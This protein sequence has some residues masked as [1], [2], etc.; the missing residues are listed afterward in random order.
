MYF[1]FSVFLLFSVF[2]LIYNKAF[3]ITLICFYSFIIKVLMWSRCAFWDCTVAQ[4][5]RRLPT[6][7]TQDTDWARPT[8][9]SNSSLTQGH[10]VTSEQFK[11]VWYVTELL[12]NIF[13]FDFFSPPFCQICKRLDR[14]TQHGQGVEG[15]KALLI[16]DSLEGLPKGPK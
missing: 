1:F 9:M 3:L 6:P 12:K 14:L 13:L 15:H 5:Y 7:A 11:I 4:L 8:E 2:G 10:K 16:Q